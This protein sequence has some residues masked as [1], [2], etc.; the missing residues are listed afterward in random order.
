HGRRLHDRV[1][2]T[3]FTREKTDAP[4]PDARLEFFSRASGVGGFEPH[5]GPRAHLARYVEVSCAADRSSRRAEYGAVL[6]RTC[7]T[8]VKTDASRRSTPSI[9]C[10]RSRHALAPRSPRSTAIVV[11]AGLE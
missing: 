3:S 9:S 1:T 10:R 5:Q 8:G 2:S 11:S 7:S 6:A 4:T